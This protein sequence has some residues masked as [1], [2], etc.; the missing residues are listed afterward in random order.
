MLWKLKM[1]I[2]FF[3]RNGGPSQRQTYR[4]FGWG[5][6]YEIYFLIQPQNKPAEPCIRSKAPKNDQIP[7]NGHITKTVYLKRH[8]E[9]KLKLKSHVECFEPKNEKI[10]KENKQRKAEKIFTKFY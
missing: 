7:I 3:S 9:K 4:N 2:L 8:M 10:R 1:Q 6:F 5:V